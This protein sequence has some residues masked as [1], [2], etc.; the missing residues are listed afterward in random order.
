[1]PNKEGGYAPN[2]TPVVTTDSAC[3]FIVDCDVLAEVSESGAAAQAV[4]RID[5]TFGR[6]P[7]KL[8]TDAGNNSGQVMQEMEAR[9]VEFYAPVESTQPQEGSPAKRDDSTQAIPASEQSKLKRNSQGHLDK[10]C[11][12][13]VPEADRYDCPQGHPMPFEKSKPCRR[14][15]VQVHVRVY[16][17]GACAGCPL[18][19]HCVSSRNQGGRTITRDEYEPLRERTASRMASPAGRKVYNQRSHLAETPF[20]ILKRVMGIR[21]FLLRGLEKVQTEWLWATT[22]F[23]LVKL[24]RA[25]GTLRAQGT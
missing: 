13:Y 9:G 20:A 11:F 14:R 5:E 7:E 24:A 22:A 21:Q 10:S 25:L 6:K 19:A 18:A 12:V 16:R 3:G 2:Y 1:M 17:C 4:D 23:N 15:G 8:L